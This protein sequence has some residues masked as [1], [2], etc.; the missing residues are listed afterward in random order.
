MSSGPSLPLERRGRGLTIS[1][2]DHRGPGDAGSRWVIDRSVDSDEP[3]PT[4]AARDLLGIVRCIYRAMRLRNAGAAELR[5]VEEIGAKL[6]R[7]IEASKKQ[8]AWHRQRAHVLANEAVLEL[9]G[10]YPEP[11]TY[12][13]EIFEGARAGV[14]AGS[15][16]RRR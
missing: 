12:A 11:V 9:N 1:D 2:T 4:E 10:L 7:A 3:F 14:M 6:G 16:G 15:R 8:N 13:K 5:R